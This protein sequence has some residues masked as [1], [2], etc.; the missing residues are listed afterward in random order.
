MNDIHDHLMSLLDKQLHYLDERSEMLMDK[1]TAAMETGDIDLAKRVLIE[2]ERVNSRLVEIKHRYKNYC[3]SK[4]A[5]NKFMRFIFI[6]IAIT[7]CLAFGASACA[8]ESEVNGETEKE[9]SSRLEGKVIKVADGD[10]FTVQIGAKK[11]KVRLLLVDSPESVDPDIPDPEPFSLEASEFT[12]KKLL[13][14][15]VQLEL[16]EVQRD[17]YDR[18]LAYCYLNGEMF[19]KQLLS[20]GLA[21]VAY[22]IPPNTKYL[23]ELEEAEDKAKKQR[24][25][26]WAGK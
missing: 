12:K 25:G 5:M 3:K 13:G 10:T 22:I 17:K 19:N 26:I 6:Y 23:D 18:L 2:Q 24:L 9:K 21:E 8:I 15:N 4:L 7:V 20:A 16:G 1:A 11:E 14:K